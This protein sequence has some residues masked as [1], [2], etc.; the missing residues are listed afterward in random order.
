MQNLALALQT[1]LLSKNSI[2]AITS[3]IAL[4]TADP[5][6]ADLPSITFEVDDDPTEALTVDASDD[7]QFPTVTFDIVAAKPSQALTLQTLV[8]RALRELNPGT[9][10]TDNGNV[11]IEEVT[12]AGQSCDSVK[13]PTDSRER[14]VYR[15][16]LILTVGYRQNLAPVS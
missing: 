9:V 10:A 3:R 2:T 16:T 5:L 14:I 1:H 11:V 15:S 6:T 7:L 12:V 4:G 13:R 8:R